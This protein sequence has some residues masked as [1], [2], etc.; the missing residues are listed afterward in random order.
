MGTATTTP[1]SIRLSHKSECTT[2]TYAQGACALVCLFL[3]KELLLKLRMLVRLSPPIFILYRNAVP[4]RLECERQL[5]M[6]DGKCRERVVA[7]FISTLNQPNQPRNTSGIMVEFFPTAVIDAVEKEVPPPARHVATADMDGVSLPKPWSRSYQH[8]QRGRMHGNS[9]VPT[10]G[11][12]PR[13]R[14]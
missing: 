5:F 6:P 9:C 7:R 13:G 11:I 8:G 4:K 14:H 12:E 3:Y 10:P 2:F 1:D